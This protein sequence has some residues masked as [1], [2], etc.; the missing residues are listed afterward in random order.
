MWGCAGVWG[1][2][3]WCGFCRHVEEGVLNFSAGGGGEG[4][5]CGDGGEGG[6]GAVLL[7]V[8]ALLQGHGR[9]WSMKSLRGFR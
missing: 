5:R 9:G 8:L 6:G 4:E 2:E 7:V 1:G 3:G